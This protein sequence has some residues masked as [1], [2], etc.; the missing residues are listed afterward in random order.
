[1]E[2][3]HKEETHDHKVDENDHEV[4]EQDYKVDEQDNKLDEKEHEEEEL[5]EQM[6]K[7]NL[8]KKLSSATKV[9]YV[10]ETI[11]SNEDAIETISRQVKVFLPVIPE[12]LVCSLRF[13]PDISPI[14]GIDIMDPDK[15]LITTV[16]H[17]LIMI[18][19]KNKAVLH[20]IKLEGVCISSPPQLFSGSNVL[21]INMLK[22][23][24]VRA[25]MNKTQF[26][27]ENVFIS[28]ESYSSGDSMRLISHFLVI[29]S[30]EVVVFATEKGIGRSLA[31]EIPY[32]TK[33]DSEGKQIKEEKL[34][35]NNKKLF[36]EIHAVTENKFG[37]I[38]MTVS[39]AN[40]SKGVITALDKDFKKLFRYVSNINNRFKTMYIA[41]TI[42]A[43]ILV[44]HLA[45]LIEILNRRGELIGYFPPQEYLPVGIPVQ[46]AVNEENVAWI[47]TACGRVACIQ[48]NKEVM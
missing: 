24:I 16:D 21:Y 39:I 19:I 14:S 6:G 48:L 5:C 20:E 44:L 4:D 10:E 26:D 41:T 33:Y 36:D 47:A 43:N 29:K 42:H 12:N 17:K 1:M 37:E 3:G 15:A 38:C 46:I 25:L 27:E 23:Q 32:V 34:M 9:G 13:D 22:F 7:T 11:E 2:K 8:A 40:E 35:E 28:L 30:N 31:E 45:N 18:D